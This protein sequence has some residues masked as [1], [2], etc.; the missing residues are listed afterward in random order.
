MFK[1]IYNHVIDLNFTAP[2]IT[3]YDIMKFSKPLKNLHLIKALS[4][5]IFFNP[6]C[7]TTS[8][9]K[10]LLPPSINYKSANEPFQNVQIFANSQ[11]Y[12]LVKRRT[13]KDLYGKLKNMTLQCVQCGIYNNSLGLTE[14]TRQ[15]IKVQ[16]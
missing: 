4:K 6:I 9:I 14:E 8:I 2:F 12:A 7:L 1:V 16:D 3:K 15:D 5:A 11:G 10:M 13:H